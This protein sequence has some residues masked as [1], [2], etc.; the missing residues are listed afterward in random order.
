MSS[1]SYAAHY[2]E[3]PHAE[4]VPHV[5]VHAGTFSPPIWFELVPARLSM[6]PGTLYPPI[7]P[8]PMAP[9][10]EAHPVA[11][12]ARTTAVAGHI[13][14]VSR[15]FP[16]FVEA[17]PFRPGYP[18]RTKIIGPLESNGGQTFSITGLADGDVVVYSTNSAGYDAVGMGFN[19]EYGVDWFYL[20]Y[21][22]NSLSGAIRIV[23]AANVTEFSFFAS[24]PMVG[25]A[26]VYRDVDTVW[27]TD[28]GTSP[29]TAGTAPQVMYYGAR[30]GQ[31]LA[32]RAVTFY[33]EDGLIPDITWAEATPVVEGYHDG[34]PSY[35]YTAYVGIAEG[36]VAGPP[37]PEEPFIGINPN[38]LN[39]SYMA[40]TVCLVESTL[41]PQEP[42][43]ENYATTGTSRIPAG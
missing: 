34:N 15:V 37:A 18:R 14:A 21:P 40:M 17:A 33:G 25:V 1:R 16:N 22:G 32:V 38:P 19:G 10:I 4:P 35:T 43:P 28:M 36:R 20:Q 6:R 3:A 31:V 9:E 41:P 12:M 23:N 13:Q 29:V 30:D 42:D 11:M 8:Q 2:L 39:D 27:L 5:E 7:R 26:A 24:G